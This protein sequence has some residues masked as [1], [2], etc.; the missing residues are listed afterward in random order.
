[1]IWKKS[2]RV[3]FLGQNIDFLIKAHEYLEKA[4]KY[5]YTMKYTGSDKERLKKKISETISE[6]NKIVEK[7]KTEIKKRTEKN[8]KQEEIF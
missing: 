6:V 1:M 8:K 4:G 2:K 5:K 7:N 3:Y